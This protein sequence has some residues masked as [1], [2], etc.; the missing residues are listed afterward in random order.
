MS[1]STNPAARRSACIHP[2]A[3]RFS[4]T[5]IVGVAAAHLGVLAL[6][7]TLAVVPLP[8]PAPL[9]ALMVDIVPPA[10][11]PPET[12]P[13]RPPAAK[14]QPQARPQPAPRQPSPP[15]LAAQ[16]EA[17]TPLAEAPTLRE[18]PPAPAVPAV[19]A[20][21]SAPA[22]VTQARFDADYLRNPAPVYPALSRRMGEEGKVLL[23]VFVEADGQPGQIE[24]RSGSGSP[25][26]DQAALDAVRRWKFVPA[27]RGDET[28]GAWVLVPIVFNLKS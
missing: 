10:P 8:A 28:I 2:A 19:P 26:L 11:L 12:S 15:M 22:P 21:P 23:R 17:A 16:T 5:A 1:A 14:R 3:P 20:A 25:R 6:L 24:T 27:R 7:A 18:M 13:P 4:A 9:N